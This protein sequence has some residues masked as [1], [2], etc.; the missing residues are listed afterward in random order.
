VASFPDK[1]TRGQ[2]D[3][4]RIYHLNPLSPCLLV[5]WAALGVSIVALGLL[6]LPSI[7]LILALG[8]VVAL[9]LLDPVF[10]LYFAVLSVPVQDLVQLPGGVTCTQAAMLL[11]T[12]AWG[13]RVLAHPERP[14]AKGWLLPLWIALLW[15]LLLATSFTPYSRAEGFK[16]VLRWGEAFLV[17]LIAVNTIQ[18]PWQAAGLLACLLLAPAVDAAI[19]LVQAVTGAGPPSFRIAPGSP[20]VRAYGTIGA[21]NSFAGYL[22]MAWPLALALTVGAIRQAFRP[23]TG[24]QPSL[25]VGRWSLVGWGAAAALALITIVLLAALVA[26][27]SRGAWLGAAAGLLAMTL[28]LGPRAGRWAIAAL[29]GGALLLALGGAGLL[30]DALATRV[31]SISKNLALFDASNVP[32]TDQNFA[33]VERMAQIQ[34]GWRMFLAH[35]FSGVGPG[36]YTPAYPDFAVGSWY[37]SRGHAH[38]YYLHMAA[39]A[40]IV[41]ALAY[42]ALLGGVSY[43]A[44]AALRRAN[45]TFRRSIA[46]GCCGIIAATAGHDLF[47][48]L[49]VLSMGIQLSVAWGLVVVLAS[50]ESRIDDRR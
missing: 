11:A 2:G 12:G 31:S 21:P 36:N 47:E 6:P 19:G 39:E 22:N 48:N 14:I 38:N 44:L 40:G 34:A 8:L 35:P 18:R 24:R 27:F 3:K 43:Q 20:L 33:V 5:F 42:L 15:A 29:C 41:G 32:V 28:A 25:V 9:S 23:A 1:G 16:E 13:L 49:H 7:A 4:E 30:P 45:S 37:A 26:S 10:G 50:W 17:W 46:I